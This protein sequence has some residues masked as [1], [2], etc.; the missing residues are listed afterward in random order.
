MTVL[1]I[2]RP[3][4]LLATELRDALDQYPE[5]AH[6]VRLMSDDDSEVGTLTEVAGAA[7]LVEAPRYR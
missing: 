7:T 5:I 2:V 3:S 1:A 4:G 6:E